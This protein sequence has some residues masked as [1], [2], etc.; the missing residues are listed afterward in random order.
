MSSI[1]NIGSVRLNC[2]AD[3]INRYRGSTVI[4][5]LLLTVVLVMYLFLFIGYNHFFLLVITNWL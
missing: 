1:K 2:N 4:V 3:E 5:E